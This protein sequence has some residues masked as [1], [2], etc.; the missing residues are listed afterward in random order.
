MKKPTPTMEVRQRVKFNEEKK[1]EAPKKEE[2]QC[3]SDDDVVDAVGGVDELPQN[4]LH[5]PWL[6]DFP[7][8]PA[9]LRQLLADPTID[10]GSRVC[11]DV[12][13]RFPVLGVSQSE[14]M[15]LISHFGPAEYVSHATGS[16]AQLKQQRMMQSFG[17]TGGVGGVEVDSFVS[18]PEAGDPYCHYVRFV[19]GCDALRCVL[20]LNG[21]MIDPQTQKQTMEQIGQ[22]V[23][24]QL[25]TL[26][27]AQEE[28]AV[29]KDSEED[30]LWEDL[31]AAMV[32]SPQ[33]MECADKG[34]KVIVVT[35]DFFRA[36]FLEHTGTARLNLV[37]SQ[38]PAATSGLSWFA[39]KVRAAKQ[40]ASRG[41]SRPKTSSPIKCQQYLL[42]ESAVALEKLYHTT[43]AE[44][45]ILWSE[46]IF[47]LNYFQLLFD[48]DP[49][50]LSIVAP[51]NYC[52]WEIIRKALTFVDYDVDLCLSWLDTAAEERDLWL[53]TRKVSV[54]KGGGNGRVAKALRKNGIAPNGGTLLDTIQ[55]INGPVAV[56][57]VALLTVIGILIVLLALK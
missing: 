26:R 52:P 36:A 32:K 12:V 22:M 11:R 9:R 34:A 8:M 42:F 13:L 21:T 14:V 24:Q 15:A 5:M 40:K 3:D 28:N 45:A 44:D 29:A 16:A 46:F 37:A 50:S 51:S 10:I 23:E 20:Q 27:Q 43:L 18:S 53:G 49:S 17:K 56:A 4:S 35:C 25:Q 31:H 6:E 55:K 2:P 19:D 57:F 47:C 33:S 30:Q 1:D 39:Q 48:H 54:S 7:R 38:H 41:K